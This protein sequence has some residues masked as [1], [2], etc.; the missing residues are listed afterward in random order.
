[1]VASSIPTITLPSCHRLVK[2]AIVVSLDAASC[3]AP[4]VFSVN[5]PDEEDD[6]LLFLG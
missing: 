2:I 1:V 5:A 6:I 3:Q 4:F